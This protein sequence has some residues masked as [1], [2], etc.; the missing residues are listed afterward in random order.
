MISFKSQRFWTC[1]PVKMVSVKSSSNNILFLLLYLDVCVIL[2]DILFSISLNFKNELLKKRLAK[3]IFFYEYFLRYVKK[4][5]LLAFL[6]C[7][8]CQIHPP[9]PSPLGINI[10]HGKEKFYFMLFKND[11]NEYFTIII[12]LFIK[13]WRGI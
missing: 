12:T 8:F 13:I 11:E 10:N 9:P 5:H 2:C 7:V 4:C 1:K 3:N 6:G